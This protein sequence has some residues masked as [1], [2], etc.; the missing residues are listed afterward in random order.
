[1]LI[2]QHALGSL[3]VKNSHF[4]RLMYE[5]MSKVTVDLSVASD[6]LVESCLFEAALESYVSILSARGFP[7]DTLYTYHNPHYLRCELSYHIK[8][9]ETVCA[10]VGYHYSTPGT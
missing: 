10:A 5:R 6:V 2:E 4:A 1:M 3:A 9:P 7:S 8:P